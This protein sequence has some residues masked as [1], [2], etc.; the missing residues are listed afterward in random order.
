[1][2]IVVTGRHV[3]VPD[4]FRRHVEDK[5]GKVEQIEPRVQRLDVML[6]QEGARGQSKA[7]ER[8]EIT[9]RSKGPVI[10]AEACSDDRYGAMD[11]A[12]EKLLE[13]LRRTRDRRKVHRGRHAPE[14][15]ATAT[16]ELPTHPLGAL[17]DSP[18]DGN[19]ADGSAPGL[20]ADDS[21]IEVREK[22]HAAVP[23]TLDQA[24]YEMELV[25]HDFFLFH[26]SDTDQASVVYRRR[27]WAYGVIHLKLDAGE[28]GVATD[29]GVDL[30][31][32]R[33]G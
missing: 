25:G 4:R 32:E 5:L 24:L 7:C 6:S 9:C 31:R 21:P 8:V 17:P 2:E 22:V 20:G 12:V 27:G 10:R 3:Q 15:V 33:V 16:A 1:V 13:R 11:L 29:A 23:M 18:P 28:A 26:D 30:R 14:S 19:E